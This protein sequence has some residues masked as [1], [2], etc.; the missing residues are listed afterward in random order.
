MNDDATIEMET[1]TQPVRTKRK[2][3]REGRERR[4]CDQVEFE[5]R[6]AVA[7]EMLCREISIKQIIG[8]FIE[9]YGVTDRQARNYCDRSAKK[10]TKMAAQ[11]IFYMRGKS[12]KLLTDLYNQST[13]EQFKLAVLTRRD[14]LL[15][16]D[17]PIK[18]KAD[19]SG[20]IEHR[21]V[22]VEFTDDW[23]RA[24]IAAEEAARVHGN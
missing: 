10:L 11:R 4:R 15:G 3:K 12:V 20:Q 8:F 21:H 5:K 1:E 13:D 6:R 7:M 18:L 23:M 16:L 24:G 17:K 22:V 19:V 14:R 9:K 2:Y